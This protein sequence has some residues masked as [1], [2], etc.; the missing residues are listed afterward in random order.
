MNELATWGTDP[1]VADTD[2][3]G[4]IDGDE[5]AA[6]TDPLNPAWFP[7]GPVI[8]VGDLL[9][10]EVDDGGLAAGQDQLWEWGVVS[11]TPN[12]G[13]SG[14][15]VWATD[16]N[17]LYYGDA[18]EF[19]YLPPLDLTGATTP[20]LTFKM[21]LDGATGD[22]VSLEVERGAAWFPIPPASPAFDDQDAIGQAAWQEQRGS[23]DTYVTVGVDLR[24]FAGAPIRM[25]FAFRSDGSRSGRGAYIDDIALTD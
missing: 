12:V 5:V 4:S 9:D 19:L 17:D 15:R 1:T 16:L 20:F 2:G 10:F 14:I 21:W 7:G 24:E 3:D 18:R 23:N 8:Q 13:S 6:G 11:G 22:G 25:R